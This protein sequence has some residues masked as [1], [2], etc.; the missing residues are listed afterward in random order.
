MCRCCPERPFVDGKYTWELR[1][2]D[3]SILWQKVTTP[4]GAVFNQEG[5]PNLWYDHPGWI[6]PSQVDHYQ[7]PPA[8]GA[9]LTTQPAQTVPMFGRGAVLANG[10]S[11]MSEMRT[12]VSPQCILTV[13]EPELG[14]IVAQI[15]LD[16]SKDTFL[17]RCGTDR[18]VVRRLYAGYYG[19]AQA[20]FRFYDHELTLQWASDLVTWRPAKDS[21][22]GL[23]T[24]F[25]SYFLWYYNTDYTDGTPN[26]TIYRLY[27]GYGDLLQSGSTTATQ[28]DVTRPAIASPI[29]LSDDG[30]GF[31]GKVTTYSDPLTGNSSSGM[32]VFSTI[33][34]S[35]IWDSVLLTSPP[36][37]FWSTGV[38][39]KTSTKVGKVTYRRGSFGT[40]ITDYVWSVTPSEP[41]W[42]AV[43]LD[44][45]NWLLFT[46]TTVAWY[47]EDQE[48]WEISCPVNVLDTSGSLPILS[49]TPISSPNRAVITLNR[50]T[51]NTQ[52]ILVIKNI[53]GPLN[54]PGTGEVTFHGYVPF[55]EH[56]SS[57]TLS[58]RVTD[59]CGDYILCGGD[60]F[61]IW[62]GLKQ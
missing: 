9:T 13:R 58:K 55:D 35:M 19:I 3:G 12:S 37:G 53:P 34:G 47:V 15:D 10:Y 11:A 7:N 56:L 25:G 8:V 36:Q 50:N 51:L 16:L 6:I 29:Q 22:G 39:L 24:P 54:V 61:Y 23:I 5:T 30:A 57:S 41:S 33:N 4:A 17:G 48:Q 21:R 52:E 42:R 27:S 18:F 14:A 43:I 38:S 1:A 2:L 60:V 32:P 31:L 46:P 59:V 45:E 49:L 40:P 26:R 44:N 28:F 62:G 20:E